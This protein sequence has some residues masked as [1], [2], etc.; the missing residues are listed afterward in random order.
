MGS[1]TMLTTRPPAER[2]TAQHAGLLAMLAFVVMFEGFDINLTT[3]VLPHVGDAYGAGAD[4]LGNAL[5]MIGLGAIAAWFMLRLADRWGRRPV[6]LLAAAGFSLGSLATVLAPSLAA[7]TAIQFVTRVL[8][9]TQIATAY[10]IVSETLPAS[11][12][13]RAIG[14]LG[15]AGSVGAALPFILLAPALDTALGWRLLFVV[16]A[17]PLVVLPLL[18]WKLRETPAFLAGR[19]KS[20]ARPTL[21]Q[22]FRALTAPGLRRRFIGMSA[23]WFLVNFA[24]VPG[25]FFFSYYVLRERGWQA[26]DLG[27]IAPAGFVAAFL[28]YVSAGWLMDVIGR[29]ATA[30][31]FATGVTLLTLVCYAS[32][33]WWIIAGCWVGMQAMFGIWIIGFTL[34]SELFPTEIRAAANGWCHNLLGRWGMVA[35]PA[36]LGWLATRIGS[37][38]D[39]AFYMGFAGLLTIPV[40]WLLLP[41]TRGVS[42]AADE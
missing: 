8:L 19:A 39:A 13:G 1:T 14:A 26:A 20:Q 6:L 12:R 31:I 21:A 18:I 42:L 9:V 32:T 27:L 22:E 23:W 2:F 36:I 29:R 40:V 30:T 11:I 35:A 15:A 38:G 7:Y 25:T 24:S 33:D 10:L 5:S 41:E 17:A 37:T 28:G 4:R 16:G 34:N 3:V